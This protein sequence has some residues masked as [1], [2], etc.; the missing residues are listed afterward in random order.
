IE[1]LM[2]DEYRDLASFADKSFRIFEK[3]N[4]KITLIRNGLVKIDNISIKAMIIKSYMLEDKKIVIDYEISFS[5]NMNRFNV[6]FSPEINVVAISYPNNTH[7]LIDTKE[8]CL[9][10]EISIQ[11]QKIALQDL[12]ENAIIKLGF[13]KTVECVIFP[14]FSIQYTNR[15]IKEYQGTSIFP[16]FIIEG[17]KLHLNIEIEI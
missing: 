8:I 17:E 12:N 16:K 7:I 2:N 1:K 14:L 11:T 3:T 13:P 15:E 9:S 10:K 6:V 4:E 5:D